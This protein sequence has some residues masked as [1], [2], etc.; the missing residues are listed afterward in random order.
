MELVD[1]REELVEVL[2][3]LPA[4]LGGAAGLGVVDEDV[5]GGRGGG[6]GGGGGGSEQVPRQPRVDLPP[7]PLQ[8]L[9]PRP[10]P[11]TRV[12]LAASLH[13]DY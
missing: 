2:L 6:G 9:V 5:V 1:A 8:V 10:H 12:R 13:V 4:G 11:R 7:A 3:V